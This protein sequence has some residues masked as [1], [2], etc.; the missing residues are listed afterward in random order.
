MSAFIGRHVTPFF[1][2]NAESKYQPCGALHFELTPKT[3]GV[4]SHIIS[5]HESLMNLQNYYRFESSDSSAY[6]NTLQ[7][8]IAKCLD[9]FGPTSRAD[10]KKNWRENTQKHKSV[11]Q[12]DTIVMSCFSLSLSV[13]ICIYM[14]IY[15][16][17]EIFMYIH[18]YIYA[19]LCIYTYIYIH[20]YIY[21]YT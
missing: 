20:T 4:Q 1:S 7:Q 18:I 19:Y 3:L 2:L 14:Y 17:T 13:Y 21:T 5:L 6:C 8:T 11:Q 10:S 15:M 16:C 9:R 12:W